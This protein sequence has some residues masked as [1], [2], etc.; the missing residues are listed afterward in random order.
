MAARKKDVNKTIPVEDY[1]HAGASRTNNP[2][3]GLAHLD[4]DETPTRRLS[5]DPH[6]DPQMVWAGKAERNESD[7]PAPSIHVHE[8]LSAQKIVGSVR[9]QRT[10]QPLFDITE[11]D[12]AK[13]VEFYQHEM[14]WT[15]RMI[16]GD[17]LVVMTSLLERE[18][19]AGNVQCIFLDPPYG[20]KYNSNFQPTIGSKSV[21]DGKDEHLT[22][23]PEMIQAYRDTWELGIHSYLTYLRDRLEVSRELLSNT[24]S[25]F[26][27]ISDEN[28]HLVRVLMD[29]V[30]GY[31]NFVSQ[32]AFTKT[33][34]LS[35][36]KKLP[37]D[38][39][40]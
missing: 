34:G 7:V 31:D 12:P 10:Q 3:A 28:V 38:L 19:L 18:R 5:F 15:N 26:L 2:P 17:S 22:R 30:F 1:E 14:N 37:V 35:A 39:T 21:T 23:E 24:G 4:R 27:Q 6:L 25:I 11:L 36:S 29:E 13:A 32:I 9:R 33:T 8:E 16:L 40:T 20:V